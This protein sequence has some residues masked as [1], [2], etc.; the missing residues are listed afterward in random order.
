MV[1][2]FIQEDIGRRKGTFINAIERLDE[3]KT[4]VL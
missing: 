3:L 1:S 2:G 4:S